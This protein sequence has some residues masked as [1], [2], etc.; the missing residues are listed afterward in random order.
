MKPFYDS[1]IITPQD[2]IIDLT[3]LEALDPRAQVLPQAQHVL[4]TP[5]NGGFVSE[6][7]FNR[8]YGDRVPAHQSSKRVNMHA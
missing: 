1:D 4:L 6:E 8:V 2:N 5:V 3:L 7:R